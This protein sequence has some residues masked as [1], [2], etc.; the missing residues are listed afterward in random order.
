MNAKEIKNGVVIQQTSL[1][2]SGLY[3][4]ATCGN[5]SALISIHAH[6]I[7]VICQNASNRVW[8]GAG[9]FFATVADAVAGYKKSD[10]KAM[11]L[12]ADAI[13]H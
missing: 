4:S 12:A 3:V 13:N 6:G 7:R 1:T 8:K 10:M 2:D 11:I 9:R 5:T